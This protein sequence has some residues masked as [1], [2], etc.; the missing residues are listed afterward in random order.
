MQKI[1]PISP[2]L[3]FKQV[4]NT[5][6]D[7]I[8]ADKNKFFSEQKAL[9]RLAVLD[10]L[11]LTSFNTWVNNEVYAE[12]P[13][14]EVAA[15][16]IGQWLSQRPDI[17]P[18]SFHFHGSVLEEDINQRQ[19]KKHIDRTLELYAAWNPRC[20]V[21]HPGTYA[22]GGFAQNKV[23]YHT[24]AERYGEDKVFELVVANI[25]YFG[26]RAAE[27]GIKV[28]VEN[29]F[30]GR[31]YS[32][33]DDLIRVV[34]AVNL[35]NVGYC[36]DSGHA[37]VDGLDIPATI[38]R[39]SDKLFELHLHDNN[40]KKDQHLPIGFGIID[41]VEV[42]KALNEINYQH[43]ITFEFPGW[44]LEDFEQRIE[45]SVLFWRTMEKV[46]YGGYNL[47]ELK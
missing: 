41:W 44:P 19:V 14:D 18:S 36:F 35:P 43:T 26:Q 10:K 39:L 7:G 4:I 30:G 8:Y 16:F 34:E 9:Q 31:F 12:N 38:H 17:R 15:K 27:F 23:V 24:M 40:G 37:N 1:F 28:A 21:L 11:G 13:D 46:A 25:G 22:P 29:L 5:V 47:F 3:Y 2:M 33:I 45:Q 6:G 42:I 20:F 32:K